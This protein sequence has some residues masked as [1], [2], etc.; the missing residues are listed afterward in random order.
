MARYVI[1][2]NIRI[3]YHGKVGYNLIHKDC[4]PWQGTVGYNLIH[5][6]CLLWQGMLY[7]IT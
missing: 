7:L 1:F 4:S 5:K 6:D 2:D 3:A